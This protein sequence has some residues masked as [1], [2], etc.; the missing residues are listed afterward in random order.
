MSLA[1]YVPSSTVC[2]LLVLGACA[3]VPVV[4]DETPFAVAETADARSAPAPAGSTGVAS[5]QGEGLS[6]M[7]RVPDGTFR[8]GSETGEPDERPTHLAQVAAFDMDVTEVTVAA[9][10]QCVA[11][12]VC[13]RAP[14][15]VQF[16][17]VTSDDQQLQDS[18]CNGD[19]LDRQDHPV[20]CIDWKMAATYCEWAGKRLPT[21]EEWEFAACGGDCDKVAGDHAG[22]A[23]ILRHER[24]PFTTPVHAAPPGL[25][26][27]YGMSGNVWEWTSSAYCPYDHPGCGDP[28]RVVR[29][30]SWSV[31]DYVFVR[32]TDRDPADPTTRNT[33]LGFRCVRAGR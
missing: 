3:K 31:V 14:T 26:G 22:E 25:F 15:M 33:N 7:A 5:S 6:D 8:M 30:G 11:V 16:P 18:E 17:G 9:Y 23:A 10:D 20:N 4:P 27:L 13:R 12:G 2:G 29:G 21:E 1:H 32:L 19:R 24:W 28:R